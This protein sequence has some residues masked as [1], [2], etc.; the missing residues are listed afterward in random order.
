MSGLGILVAARHVWLQHSLEKGASC[1]A[2]IN[3]LFDALPF[4]D[5]IVFFF[6]TGISCTE[7]KWSMLGFSIPELTLVLFIILYFLSGLAV[8]NNFN[9]KF[10]KNKTKNRNKR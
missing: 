1:V 10:A 3:Y 7:V 2:D 4:Q 8:Y 9:S 5:F 6:N